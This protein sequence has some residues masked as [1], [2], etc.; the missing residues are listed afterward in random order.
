MF[1]MPRPTVLVCRGKNCVHRKGVR[2]RLE[3]EIGKVAEVERVSCQNI[4]SGPVVGVEIEG[5]LEWFRRIR[6]KKSRRALVKLLAEEKLSKRLRK[7]RAKKRSG[8]LR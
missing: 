2:E 4:C 1:P 3:E 6:G 5:R 8:K 7:R